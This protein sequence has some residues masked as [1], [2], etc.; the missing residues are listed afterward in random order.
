MEAIFT[1]QVPEAVEEFPSQV[2][3]QFFLLIVTSGSEEMLMS[4]AVGDEHHSRKDCGH[5]VEP[6]C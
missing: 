2:L 4:T 6:P 3:G 5:E 1:V